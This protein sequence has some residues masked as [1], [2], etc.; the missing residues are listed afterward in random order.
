V[1]DSA[2]EARGPQYYDEFFRER[3]PHAIGEAL[4]RRWNAK[5]LAIAEGVI[6]E[7]ASKRIV[8]VGPGLGYFAE[9]AVARGFRYAAI[10]MNSANAERLRARGIEVTCAAVPPFPD[11][12][13]IDVLWLQHVLEHARDFVE[14]REMLE[15]GLRR[16]APGGHVVVIAPDVLS[17]GPYFYEVD[18]SHGYPTTLGRVE[19]LL[20]EV[21]LE[22]VFARHHAAGNIHAPIVAL[23]SS[24]S[25]LVPFTPL[26]L[27]ARKLTGRRLFFS[28][29]SMFG[30]RQIYVVGKQ[31]TPRAR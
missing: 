23:T 26:D 6:P 19:Q 30:W 4:F 14:A 22:V 29:V 25:Q 12:P 15:A 24:L 21:G 18:W 1:N 7:L 11:G 27:V 31:R 3:R 2:H 13:A 9:H 10:E 8:E 5:M 17:W 28:L 20:R 16:L